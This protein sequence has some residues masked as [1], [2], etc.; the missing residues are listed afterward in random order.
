MTENA[1][2]R[3]TFSGSAMDLVPPVS[4]PRTLARVLLAAFALLVLLLALT[5]WQQ[6]APASGRVVAYAPDE[7]QQNLEAPIEGRVLRWYVREGSVVEA[8][9]PIVDL[10]DNDPEILTRLRSERDAIEARL[11]AA[12]ARAHALEARI[13]AL[14]DS[15]SSAIAAAESRVLMAGQRVAAA[16]QAVTLAQAALAAAEL[17]VERQSSL[18]AAG[19][20]SRRQLELTELERTRSRTELERARVA[21]TAAKAERAA[22]T[23]DRSKLDT[24]ADAGIED[25]RASQAAAEAEVANAS[26]ELARVEVRLARQSAQSVVAPRSGS[27]FRVIANGHTGEIVKAGDVL[28]TLVPETSERAVELWVSG[29][30]LPLVREGAD[31][32]LQFEGWPAAQFSGW[33]AVAVGTFGGRV[34]LLDAADDGAGKFRVLVVPPPDAAWPAPIYLRQGVRA[35]GWIQLGRVRLGYEL[36][37]QLNG[38]PPSLPSAPPRGEPGANDK[39]GVK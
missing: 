16:E 12:R 17:N 30:D 13:G 33:P 10:S 18:A 28:A 32:R 3:R 21:L 36:W 20:T 37:R 9:D 1:A 34:S 5:P 14:E 6:T 35:L 15:G 23:S 24:D 25:A 29:N 19:L 11:D 27:V 8:G 4:A 39:G 38:F 26:A 22:L 2:S 31:V 7:R